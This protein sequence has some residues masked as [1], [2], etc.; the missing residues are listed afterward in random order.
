MQ[1]GAFPESNL[2]KNE[3]KVT[4]KSNVLKSNI[5]FGQKECFAQKLVRPTL[6][7]SGSAGPERLLYSYNC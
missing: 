7:R 4:Q 1:F 6:I 3:L 5:I 2:R